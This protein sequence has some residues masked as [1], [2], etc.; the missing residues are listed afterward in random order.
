[1]CVTFVM[2]P[3]MLLEAEGSTPC[4]RIAN[5]PDLPNR[6]PICRSAPRSQVMNRGW[7]LWTCV[8]MV[9]LVLEARAESSGVSSIGSGELQ[10]LSV[11]PERLVFRGAGQLQQLIITGHYANGG[12]RDLTASA[13]FR[14]LDAKVIRLEAGGL[15]VSVGNGTSEVAT[16]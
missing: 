11:L 1:M 15:L 5:S 2:C 13:G 9:L 3:G 6:S 14:I 12:V 10:S 16:E 4:A 8:G 7:L